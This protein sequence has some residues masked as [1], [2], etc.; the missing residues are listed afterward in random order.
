MPG[1]TQTWILCPIGVSLDIRIRMFL[2]YWAALPLL[3]YTAEIHVEIR[4]VSEWLLPVSPV[5]SKPICLPSV[6]ILLLTRDIINVLLLPV[7]AQ[8]FMWMYAR[9][10]K[11]CYIPKTSYRVGLRCP[12]VDLAYLP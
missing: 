6:D 9:L 5:E 3:E 11:Q 10:S 1:D 2:S 4:C 7:P 8:D 12:I